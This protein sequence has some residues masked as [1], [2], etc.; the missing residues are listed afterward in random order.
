MPKSAWKVL[1]WFRSILQPMFWVSQ[2]R[3]IVSWSQTWSLPRQRRVPMW[4]SLNSPHPRVWG[5]DINV[6]EDQPGAFLGSIAV[7]TT[8]PSRPSR[9]LATPARPWWSCPVWP[10]MHPTDLILTTWSARR[11]ARRESALSTWMMTWQLPSPTSA[12]N[13]SRRKIS[14][15]LSHCDSK[16]E[17]IHFKVGAKIISAEAHKIIIF[18]AAGFAHKT[19]PQNIDLNCVRLAFQVFLEGN[20]KGAFTFALKPVISDPIYDRSKIIRKQFKHLTSKK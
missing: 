18:L 11:G 8:K 17:S 6:K 14:M 10:M 16:S 15:S 3:R 7:L 19:S 4:R 1:Y 5:S 2:E 20:E 13:V 9:W 12:S